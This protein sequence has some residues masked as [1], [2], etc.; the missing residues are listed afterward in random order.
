VKQ[1]EEERIY[2]IWI[3]SLPTH[4]FAGTEQKS[5]FLFAGIK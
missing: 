5:L 3:S 2:V 4:L 1:A